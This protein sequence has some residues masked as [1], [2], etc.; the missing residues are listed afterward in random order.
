MS[1][2]TLSY[3]TRRW[4]TWTAQPGENRRPTMHFRG[5]Y[6]METDERSKEQR[7]DPGTVRRRYVAYPSV[8]V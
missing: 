6:T 7:N 8:A 4:S 5:V 2:G 1:A 3:K